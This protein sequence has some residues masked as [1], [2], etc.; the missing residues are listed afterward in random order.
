MIIIIR[1]VLL[2]Q[3]EINSLL[4]FY[5]A[6]PHISDIKKFLEDI[7]ILIM[8][9]EDSRRRMFLKSPKQITYIDD[10]LSDVAI[11]E[12]REFC[13]VSKI[14]NREYKDKYLG[15]TFSASGF[16][17]PVHLQ[18]AIDLKQKLPKLFGQHS[19]G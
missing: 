7:L 18:I 13:L 9:G 3:F 8:I 15:A 2:N 16:N 11:R 5:K 14:W 19:I 1:K 4:P 12:L 17:S 10:F 6:Q